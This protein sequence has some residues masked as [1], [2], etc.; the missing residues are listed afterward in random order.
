MERG[1]FVFDF[2]RTK[3][4]LWDLDDTLYNRRS[5]AEKLFSDMMKDLLYTGQSETF[6]RE[7]ASVMLR[8]AGRENMLRQETFSA[9]FRL[10]P[11]DHPFNHAICNDYYLENIH[12]YIDG[13]YS[14]QMEIVRILRDRNIRNAIVTNG[15]IPAVQWRKISVMHLEN[16]FDDIL[17]S[18]EIGYHKPDPRIYDCA[19]KRLG[20][21]NNDCL[22]VGDS[23]TTDIP[24]AIAAG[25]EAV[26]L[27][28][29]DAKNVFSSYPSVS[30]IRQIDEYF[31]N[32]K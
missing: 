18:G 31:G 12:R 15:K 8:L 4:V 25:M 6:Y 3:A 1:L 20:M 21:K 7:V 13:P 10:Y 27:D 28:V 24:G 5:A 30:K 9:L 11:P 32:V 19:A 26:W 16:E 14:R 29:L 17:V 23:D 22:F 2:N